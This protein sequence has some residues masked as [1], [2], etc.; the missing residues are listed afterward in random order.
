MR[1]RLTQQ[2]TRQIRSQDSSSDPRVSLL[3][4]FGEL[5]P[6]DLGQLMSLQM[7]FGNYLQSLE[8]SDER[9]T[10]VVDALGNMIADQEQTTRDFVKSLQQQKGGI[11]PAAMGRQ[12]VELNSRGNQLETLSYSL[13]QQELD[14]LSEYWET[15]GGQAMTF[16]ISGSSLSAGPNGNQPAI[17]IGTG[18]DGSFYT[19][20]LRSQQPNN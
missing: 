16:E 9:M 8:I 4:Q 19:G 6:E 5:N 7:Q 11:D 14:A 20:S 1:Q 17:F 3:R 2:I 18:R 15:Q 10:V 12:I 13:N